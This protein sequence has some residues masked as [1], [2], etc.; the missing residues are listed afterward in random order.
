MHKR[1]L[2]PLVLLL[3]VLSYEKTAVVAVAAAAASCYCCLL[4]LSVIVCRMVRFVAGS[5]NLTPDFS[6]FF[7]SI[8][9]FFF[10]TPWYCRI[11]GLEL[12]PSSVTTAFAEPRRASARRGEGPLVY[13]VYMA[14]TRHPHVFIYVYDVS[15]CNVN[16]RY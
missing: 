10:C 7:L 2:L 14:F 13:T 4:L 5:L 12:P 8:R 15:C 1:V 16:T 9:F 3:C 11:Y 6:V